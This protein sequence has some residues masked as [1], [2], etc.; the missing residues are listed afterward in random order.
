MDKQPL[1]GHKDS[2]EDI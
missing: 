2:V 1:K